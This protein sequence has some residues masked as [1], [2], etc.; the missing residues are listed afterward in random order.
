MRCSAPKWF[1]IAL[2]LTWS[3]FFNEADAEA[4]GHDL[5]TSLVQLKEMWSNDREFVKT[6]KS[7][8]PVM[9]SFTDAS[10]RSVSKK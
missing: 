8:L 1:A 7:I 10:K 4:G 3:C 5:F 9:E 6:L 2:L